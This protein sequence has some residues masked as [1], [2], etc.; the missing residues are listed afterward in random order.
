MR[1]A[2]PSTLEH[3]SAVTVG[4]PGISRFPSMVVPSVHG[5]CDRAESSFAA[6]YPARPF[7]CR[8]FDAALAG[9]AARPGAGVDRLPFTV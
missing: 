2:A 1:P 6:E 5:V 7:P 9:T 8:R 4:G 3:G